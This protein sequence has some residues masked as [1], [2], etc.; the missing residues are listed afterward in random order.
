MNGLNDKSSKFTKFRPLW[1]CKNLS[2]HL[3]D[4]HNGDQVG[5]W[6]VISCDEGSVL[7]EL[8]FDEFQWAVQIL[9]SCIQL[10]L[11]DVHTQNLG[12]QKLQPKHKDFY[13]N[14]QEVQMK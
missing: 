14:L 2:A 6:H 9:Q 7:D 5:Q 10:V 8:F 12:N 13:L 3:H 11:G 4:L 1:L